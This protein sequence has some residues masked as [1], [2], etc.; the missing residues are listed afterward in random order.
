[1]AGLFAYALNGVTMLKGNKVMHVQAILPTHLCRD[2][3]EARRRSAKQSKIQATSSGCIC[4]DTGLPL[5]PVWSTYCHLLPAVTALTYHDLHYLNSFY[6]ACLC[7]V[8]FAYC[9]LCPCSSVY[10]AVVYVL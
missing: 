10:G 9:I 5:L 1:M 2:P 7:T 6:C 3:A 4:C 8:Y